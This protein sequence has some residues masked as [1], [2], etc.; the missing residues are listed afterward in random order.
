MT[1]KG[2]ARIANI[3]IP[4]QLQRFCKEFNVHPDTVSDH[5]LVSL[6]S[7]ISWRAVE[8]AGLEGMPGPRNY[9]FWRGISELPLDVRVDSLVAQGDIP[10]AYIRFAKTYEAKI[11]KTTHLLVLGFPWRVSVVG[12]R[13]NWYSSHCIAQW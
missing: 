1:F 13:Q 12:A 11:D 10:N 8:S 3:L 2:E 7:S 6:L 5:A 4:P 9:V